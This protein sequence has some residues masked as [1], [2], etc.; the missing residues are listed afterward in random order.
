MTAFNPTAFRQQF[1]ALADAG[2]YLDSA[3][4]TLKPQA[5][6]DSTQQFY[7][8]S[9]GTVH[10]SQFAA[11]QALTHRYERRAT[12]LPAGLMPLTIVRLSGRAA[13]PKR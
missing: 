11:A 4:T 9:A 7:S 13:P 12:R 6:I 3:A 2:V 8:L 1:P 10:R 5:V